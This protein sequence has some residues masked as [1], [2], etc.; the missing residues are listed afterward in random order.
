MSHLPP[1][2]WGGMAVATSKKTQDL[3]PG[4]FCYSSDS[5]AAA[6]P[7][8]SPFVPGDPP[9]A[10]MGDNATGPSAIGGTPDAPDELSDVPPDEPPDAPMV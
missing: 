6:D 8:P 9:G 4:I 3:L 10:G 2:W 7:D 1:P 5:I